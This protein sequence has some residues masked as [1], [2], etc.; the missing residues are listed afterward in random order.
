[1]RTTSALLSAVVVAA[2]IQ[3]AYSFCFVKNMPTVSA[4]FMRTSEA[5]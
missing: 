1:M 3:S 2:T 5:V 4:Y